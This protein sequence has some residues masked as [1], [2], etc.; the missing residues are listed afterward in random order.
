MEP[1]AQL[2]LPLLHEGAW[3]DDQAAFEVAARDQLLD[4]EAGHDRLAGPGII[5]EQEAQRLARQHLLVD[6]GDLVGEGID[7]GRV[8]RQDGVEQVGEADAVGL[9]D[10]AEQRTVAV[11]APRPSGLGNLE[12]RL[13]VA[14]QDLV[15]DL[16]GGGLV[17]QLDRV[18]AEPLRV[19]HGDE[20]VRD[21]APDR[22]SW[23]QRFERCDAGPP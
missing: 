16:A 10:Q 5:R 11:E 15:G 3:A 6:R 4:Q 19:D 18:R 9:G 21:E 2:V 23:G 13:V 14:I 8:D 12:A 17:R 22:R 20:G 1:A 7:Q